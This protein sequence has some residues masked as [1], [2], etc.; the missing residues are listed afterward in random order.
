MKLNIGDTIRIVYAGI[1]ALGANGCYG[2]VTDLES[3]HGL[4]E[5][6][7]GFNVK[8]TSSKN[9][10]RVGE[11]WR[12]NLKSKYYIIKRANRVK[13]FVTLDAIINDNNTKVFVEDRLGMAFK[14]P[15]DPNKEWVGVIIATMRAYGVEE[16][17]VQRV[18]DSIFED[19][20]SKPLKE[21]SS[22]EL[23]KEIERRL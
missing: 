5:D 12:I 6:K 9:E 10:E 23:L 3:S 16:E 14:N 20:F 17:V 15:S 19:D 11:V 13:K 22:A 4:N 21:Y 8:I 7:K 18:I 1:G 2:V